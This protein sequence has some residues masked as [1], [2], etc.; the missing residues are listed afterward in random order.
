MLEVSEKE[1]GVVATH[2]P[3]WPLKTHSGLELVLRCEP[4]TYQLCGKRIRS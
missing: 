3:I 1:E 4:S 2:L